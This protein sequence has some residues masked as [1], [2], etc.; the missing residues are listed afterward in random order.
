[1]KFISHKKINKYYSIKTEKK[2][3][4]VESKFLD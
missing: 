2:S 4:R 3:M 1:M